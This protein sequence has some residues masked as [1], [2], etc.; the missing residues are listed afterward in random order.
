MAPGNGKQPQLTPEQLAAQIAQQRMMAAAYAAQQRQV[1]ATALLSGILAGLY[2][3]PELLADDF[4]E[5]AVNDA[6][7]FAD[8]LHDRL[9]ADAQAQ[10]KATAP[11]P[12]KAA[13][14]VTPEPPAA[15]GES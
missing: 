10:L 2:S 1:M 3:N 11:Q 9:V 12:D 4:G 7:V 14:E 15:A 6:I 5:K 8:K 13:G